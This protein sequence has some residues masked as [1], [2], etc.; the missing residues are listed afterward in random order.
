MLRHSVR[1]RFPRWSQDIHIKEVADY[2]L[3]SGFLSTKQRSQCSLAIP[4]PGFRVRWPCPTHQRATKRQES[5]T[6]KRAPPAVLG[7]GCK[8]NAQTLAGSEH[9]GL[10][11]H[12]EGPRTG[13]R[14]RTQARSAPER[15]VGA[16]VGAEP[17]RRELGALRRPLPPPDPAEGR[18]RTCGSGTP[19]ALHFRT[20]PAVNPARQRIR[21]RRPGRRR[22][23][24]PR[25]ACVPE[26]QPRPGTAVGAA[27]ERPPSRVR[28]CFPASEGAAAASARGACGTRSGAKAGAR[29]KLREGRGRPSRA[30]P[31]RWGSRSGP[32]TGA[33]LTR[34]P[35]QVGVGARPPRLLRGGGGRARRRGGVP[36]APQV[37]RRVPTCVS[38]RSGGW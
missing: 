23:F 3:G 18:P 20:A 36:L 27:A 6:G 30:S 19:S 29:G 11:Q 28:G 35:P 10:S 8:L 32:G 33:G 16:R 13:P 38:S 26:R 1:E 22:D 31:G 25:R 9:T 4:R 2:L 14:R 15:E 7:V 5:I 17:S 37:A 34:E 21:R 24:L 12:V